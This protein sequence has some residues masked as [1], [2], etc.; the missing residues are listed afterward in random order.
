MHYNLINKYEEVWLLYILYPQ[1]LAKIR[2]ASIICKWKF[3]CNMFSHI[4]PWTVFMQGCSPLGL[5]FQP[6][7]CVPVRASRETSAKFV[8]HS[9]LLK[10]SILRLTFKFIKLLNLSPIIRQEGRKQ[11]IRKISSV[12]IFPSSNSGSLATPLQ[13]VYSHM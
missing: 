9:I 13:H 5:V 2:V 1:Y 7:R 12:F 4:H 3:Q 11:Q 8:E 6:L 10:L